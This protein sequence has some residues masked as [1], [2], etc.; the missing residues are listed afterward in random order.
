MIC[1]DKKLLPGFVG[2]LKGLQIDVL[3]KDLRGKRLS[4]GKGTV[5]FVYLFGR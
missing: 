1:L 2:W 5:I 3:V 4:T